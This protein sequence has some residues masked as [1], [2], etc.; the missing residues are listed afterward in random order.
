MFHATCVYGL[1][2]ESIV[3]KDNAVVSGRDRISHPI[4]VETDK[5]T[6]RAVDS[7]ILTLIFLGPVI[8]YLPYFFYALKKGGEAGILKPRIPY[9]VSDVSGDGRSLLIN[10]ETIDTQFEPDSW[11]YDPASNGGLCKN[12]LVQL[13]A[14][15]RFKINGH[16]ADQF[17]AAEFA[18]CLHRRMQ[19]LCSQYGSNDSDGG[20]RFSEGWAIKENMLAWS[21]FTHYSARQNKVMQLGG[22]SGSMVLSGNFTS[23]EY[24]SLK[25]AEIF[26]AGKNT[27]FGLGKLSIWVKD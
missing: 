8:R 22:V 20:Y 19:T 2:F 26:H 27:N 1:V 4:I 3:P 25:F 11:E 18:L 23:Y 6:E 5:F 15:L 7:L 14:P 12:L 13:D 17:S 21:D 10:Q 16:Y 9:V 24:A